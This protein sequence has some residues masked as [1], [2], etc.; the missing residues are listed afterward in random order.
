MICPN[1]GTQ[2]P[3]GS[4]G[5]Q[6]CGTQFAYNAAPGYAP[7][8][9]NA[10]ILVTTTNQIEGYQIVDYITIVTGTHIYTVG[11]MLGGGLANQEKLFSTAYKTALSNMEA[12]ARECKADAVVGLTVNF[13]GAANT[14]SVILA[15]VG[16]AVKIR[17]IE[18]DK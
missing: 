17:K 12:R 10:K 2:L 4:A 18:T 5:C 16:T 1:C 8:P 15:L 6:R 11:G 9:P 13:T 14:G 3:D 7:Y